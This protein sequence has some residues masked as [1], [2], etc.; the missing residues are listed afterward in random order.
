MLFF[1]GVFIRGLFS[2][3]IRKASTTSDIS[4]LLTKRTKAIMPVHLFGLPVDM[5]ALMEIAH[6]HNLAV[7]EDCAQA[8]GASW[9]GQKVGSIGNIGCFSFYPTKNL[10]GCGD[11]GAITTNNREIADKIRLLKEHGSKTI[12]GMRIR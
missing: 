11:G 9:E 6:S 3:S 7:I 4:L 8:T 12:F 10:G 5:T 1:F 2:S